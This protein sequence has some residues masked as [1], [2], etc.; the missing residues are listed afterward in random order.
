[1]GGKVVSVTT[2]GFITDIVDLE[3]K[4]SDSYLL[5]KYKVIRNDLSGNDQ[6]LELKSA[7]VGVMA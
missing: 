3:S 5:S 7:G 2:D 6:G 4:I 1:L